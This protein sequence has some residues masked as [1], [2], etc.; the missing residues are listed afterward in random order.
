MDIETSEK[1]SLTKGMNEKKKKKL[2]WIFLTVCLITF[3]FFLILIL[4]LNIGATYEAGKGTK[5][6]PFQIETCDQLQDI[7]KN[8]TAHYILIK[9]ISCSSHNFTPIGSSETPFS[10]SL[11]GDSYTISDLSI[12]ESLPKPSETNSTQNLGALSI[13]HTLQNSKITNLSILSLSF[14]PH[15]SSQNPSNPSKALN[16]SLPLMGAIASYAFNSHLSNLTVHNMLF[17]PQNNVDYQSSLR[18]KVGGLVSYAQNLTV[19]K[20]RVRVDFEASFVNSGGIVGDLENGSILM[21]EVTGRVRGGVLDSFG[22]AVGILR[23]EGSVLQFQSDLAIFGDAERI[24]GVVGFAIGKGKLVVQDV[25]L[26]GKLQG[27]GDIGGIVGSVNKQDDVAIQNVVVFSEEIVVIRD[28]DNNSAIGGVIGGLTLEGD[29]TQL[30]LIHIIVQGEIEGMNSHNAMFI[31]GVIGILM[32]PSVQLNDVHSVWRIN[33]PNGEKV[34][35]ICGNFIHEEGTFQNVLVEGTI[36][37]LEDVGGII[38][39]FNSQNQPHFTNLQSK[40]EII[41]VRRVGGIIGSCNSVLSLSKCH[42]FFKITNQNTDSITNSIGGLIGQGTEVYLSE[43]SSNVKIDAE[44]AIAVGGL[45]GFLKSGIISLSFSNSTITAHSYIGSLIG[46][47]APIIPVSQFSEGIPTS[48][49]SLIPSIY[50]SEL[51]IGASPLTSI[52]DSYS[53]SELNVTSY[54]GGLIGLGEDISIKNCFYQG[55]IKMQDGSD[56]NKAKNVGGIVGKRQKGNVRNTYWD[57]EI[58]KLTHSEGGDARDTLQMSN[59][60]TYKFW[61]FTNVWEMKESTP[62]LKW[63]NKTN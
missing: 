12:H 11:N 35:G 32:A 21:C 33:F 5:S 46:I 2:I 34:G 27:F 56:V 15:E 52:L 3:I 47:T 39:K 23:G 38:G 9:N 44:K 60:S 63:Q 4:S 29:S 54:A 45:I 26:N 62:M 1:V 37:G 61:D 41:G 57:K 50:V 55:E 24:G 49:N 17:K 40:A 14:H 13:F 42:T 6:N 51:A 7:S 58:S 19:Q 48:K 59:K 53:T 36:H 22:G 31:G 16:H 28:E 8:L 10:G 18:W 20:C 25:R 30:S 43:C